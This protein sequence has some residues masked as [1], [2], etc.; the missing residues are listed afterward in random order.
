MASPGQPYTRP[1]HRPCWPL[2][3]WVVIVVRSLEI[4]VTSTA[5]SWM[6]TS[7]NISGTVSWVQADGGGRYRAGVSRRRVYIDDLVDSTD[8]ARL[9]GLAGG[10]VV[11][12]YQAR[13]PDMPRP[14]LDRG[15]RRAKLWLRSEVEDWAAKR[16]V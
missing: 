15:P 4:M 10:N 2:A 11:S 5:D 14:V 3:Q 6:L 12:V 16:R 13:Y 8:V 1:P 7:A 9:L